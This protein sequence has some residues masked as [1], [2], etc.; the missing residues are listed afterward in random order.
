MY[1]Y[2][3]DFPTSVYGGNPLFMEKCLVVILM[4][5]YYNSLFLKSEH[6]IVF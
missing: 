4:R 3:I 5:L 6:L 1:L 2:I